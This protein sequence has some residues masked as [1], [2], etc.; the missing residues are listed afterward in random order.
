MRLGTAA[1]TTQGMGEAE[2]AR[3]AVLF[4]ARSVE[5]GRE[6]WGAEEVRELAGRF[7]PYPGP[8]RGS[9]QLVHRRTCNHRRYPEVPDPWRPSLGCGAWMT[10]ETC[11]EARA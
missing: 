8:G 11:G 5:D 10:S 9:R 1:V 3:I 6:R 2:M 4:T 7:P